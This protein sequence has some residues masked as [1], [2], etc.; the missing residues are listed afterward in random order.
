MNPITLPEIQFFEQ[1]PSNA[2]PEVVSELCRLA[3]IGL[4]GERVE[5][6][7]ARIKPEIITGLRD[8]AEFEQDGGNVE[9]G[10]AI[11]A[12]LDWYEQAALPTSIRQG[13]KT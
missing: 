9:Q 5:A 3:K 2:S 6:I 11:D 7:K 12:I 1:N 13:A 4:A 8:W 10:A